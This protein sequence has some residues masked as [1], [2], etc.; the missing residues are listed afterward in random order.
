MGIEIRAFI[1]NCE[2]AILMCGETFQV[3]V[4]PF[5]IVYC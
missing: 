2:N 5:F 4:G 3:T 1:P